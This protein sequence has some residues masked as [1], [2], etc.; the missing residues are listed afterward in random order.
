MIHIDTIQS[1]LCK[2]DLGMY[3][4]FGNEIK[5]NTDLRHSREANRRRGADR[6]KSWWQVQDVASFH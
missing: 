3:L 1:E 5:T 2:K 6:Q 4:L